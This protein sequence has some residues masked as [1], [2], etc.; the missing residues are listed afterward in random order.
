[1]IL[2]PMAG[3]IFRQ[4]LFDSGALPAGNPLRSQ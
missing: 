3:A 1:M 4:V 2:R